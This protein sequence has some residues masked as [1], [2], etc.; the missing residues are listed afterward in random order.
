MRTAILVL[1][2]A[3]A[4]PATA[5]IA[6]MTAP[7]HGTDLYYSVQVAQP[8]MEYFAPLSSYGAASTAGPVY[9]VGSVPPMLYASSPPPVFPPNG[10]YLT[11]VPW[12]ISPY[13]LISHPQFSRDGAVFAFMGRRVCL[14][15]KGCLNI[16]LAQTT[17]RT[18]RQSFAFEGRGW[19]SGNGR[20]LLIQ[21]E[22]SPDNSDRPGLVDLETGQRQTVPAEAGAS[23]GYRESTGRM[24]A[25]DGTAVLDG[26]AGTALCIFRA[27]NL[28]RVPEVAGIEPVIDAG[29]RNIVYTAKAASGTQYLRAYDLATGQDR[30]FV[31]PNGDTNAPAISADG[32]RV[33]FLSTAQWGTNNPPGSVQ[34]YAINLDGTGFMELTSGSE[35]NGIEQ[36]TMSDDGQVAWYAAGGRLVR[37]DLS[38]GEVAHTVFRPAIADLSPTL[39]PGSAVTL[40]GAQLSGGIVRVNG[41]DAPL[42]SATQDSITFQVPWDVQPDAPATLQVV[43]NAGTSEEATADAQTSPVAARPWLIPAAPC[44]RPNPCSLGGGAIHQDWSAYVTPDNPARPGEIVHLYGTGF[45]PVAPGGITGIPA[46]ADTPAQVLAKPTCTG[47]PESPITLLYLGLAPGLVGYY[48]MDVQ[49]P[50]V[51]NGVHP[52]ENTLWDQLYIACGNAIT[53]F[54]IRKP[55]VKP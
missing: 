55:G 7:G 37:L 53:V 33:M 11:N 10:I 46:P 48:Q 47:D 29:G 41:I 45:G 24:V 52:T 43:T 23:A 16:K 3:V 4:R 9:R 15:G 6:E 25:D 54:V 31:Q 8:V 32:K 28:I 34:L 51:F 19:L 50:A 21:P 27:G 39:V 13:Y 36:Y 17:V 35:P 42:L 18:S 44:Q 5:Q 1:C 40:P 22:E 30:M 26:C 2:A 38:A 14:D 49:L 12:F 20:F